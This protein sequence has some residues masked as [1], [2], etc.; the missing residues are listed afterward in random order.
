MKRPLFAWHALLLGLITFSPH[1]VRCQSACTCAPETDTVRGR[2]NRGTYS[3]D[4]CGLGGTYATCYEAYLAAND[5]W[6]SDAFEPRE[7]TKGYW[8]ID[9][10]VEAIILPAAPDD[11]VLSVTW[12]AIDS[13]YGWLRTAFE[14]LEEKFGPYVL[15]KVY[16]GATKFPGSQYFYVQFDSL[17]PL[18]RVQADLSVIDSI[19]VACTAGLMFRD[20]AIKDNRTLIVPDA[21]VIP[22]PARERATIS[23]PS[24]PPLSQEQVS[25]SDVYSRRW[26]IP[27]LRADETS[28]TL[29]T[30]Q[31]SSGTYFVTLGGTVARVIVVK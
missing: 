22:L 30:S 31:L 16:P 25:V 21:S 17:V 10:K 13:A 18:H 29:D 27:V 28:L 14:A 8:N 12:R 23:L 19:S 5:K 26:F 4:T 11:S 2:Y 7:Y 20:D 6:G 24:R 15:I 3:I 1:L 9:F